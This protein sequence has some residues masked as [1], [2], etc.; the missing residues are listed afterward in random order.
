[1]SYSVPAKYDE[2]SKVFLCNAL[3]PTLV[4]THEGIPEMVFETSY[5]RGTDA[6]SLPSRSNAVMH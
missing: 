5:P 2:I 1:M 4:V 3:S 6:R